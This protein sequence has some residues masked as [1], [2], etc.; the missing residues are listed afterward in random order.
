MKGEKLKRRKTDDTA[1]TY[2]AVTAMKSLME[3]LTA[4]YTPVKGVPI[5]QLEK[6]LNLLK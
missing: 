1:M 6:R 2:S 3:K 4:H 5:D